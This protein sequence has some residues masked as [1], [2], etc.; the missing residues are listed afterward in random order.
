MNNKILSIMFLSFLLNCELASIKVDRNYHIQKL[1]ERICW[2]GKFHVSFLESKNGKVG[3]SVESGTQKAIS[4]CENYLNDEIE[5]LV[6]RSSE[7]ERLNYASFFV[8][9]FIIPLQES[10]SYYV[11]V[12]KGKFS[13]KGPIMLNRVMSP[14]YILYLP[15]YFFGTKYEDLVYEEVLTHILEVEEQEKLYAIEKKRPTIS[16]EKKFRNVF[17]ECSFDLY[18]CAMNE[19]IKHRLKIAIQIERKDNKTTSDLDEL[20]EKLNT[21]EKNFAHGCFCRTN[22]DPTLFSKCPVESDFDSICEEKFNCDQLKPGDNSCGITFLNQLTKLQKKHNE[23]N[24]N[25]NYLKEKIKEQLTII[26][27]KNII[28]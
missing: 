12:S 25:D 8:S 22:P 10:E 17:R 23:G 13:S 26:Y 1:S 15:N 11:K 20:R 16:F 27:L 9:L 24:F 28:N 4:Q 2:G 19:S 5:V 14:W 3:D 6:E 7:D 18:E 21:K